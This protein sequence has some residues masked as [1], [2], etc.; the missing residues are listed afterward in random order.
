MTMTAA[1]ATHVRTQHT[2]TYAGARAAVDAAVSRAE[3]LEVAALG[4]T[5]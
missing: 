2:L 3:Q 1:R 5:H 4:G